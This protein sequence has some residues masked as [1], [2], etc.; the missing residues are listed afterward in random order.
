MNVAPGEI[1]VNEVVAVLDEPHAKVWHVDL[2]SKYAEVLSTDGGQVLLHA[3]ERALGVDP[4]RAGCPTAF[5]LGL[6]DGW[7]V[8]AECT[9]GTLRIVAYRVDAQ[10]A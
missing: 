9:K 3:G 5:V 10:A 2:G 8:L 4:D 6:G 1:R 7:D